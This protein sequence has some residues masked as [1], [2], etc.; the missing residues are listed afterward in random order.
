VIEAATTSAWKIEE[1]ASGIKS[2]GVIQLELII[3][4]ETYSGGGVPVP[5][6]TPGPFTVGAKVVVVVVGST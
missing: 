3:C 1:R 4:R 5:Q 2:V 6:R